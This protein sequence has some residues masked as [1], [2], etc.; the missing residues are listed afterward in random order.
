MEVELQAS[1]MQ[2]YKL[3]QTNFKLLQTLENAQK[4]AQEVQKEVMDDSEERENLIDELVCENQMLRQALTELPQFDISQLVKT[5]Q[6]GQSSG[7]TSTV[8]VMQIIRDGQGMLKRR[9]V[10]IL[11]KKA[12]EAEKQVKEQKELNL[13]SIQPKMAYLLD[14]PKAGSLRS[15]PRI[16]G[17]SEASA[18]N[19]KDAF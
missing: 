14:S 16:N 12:E 18:F 19:F 11:Q 4:N 2:E 8:D 3:K 17:E 13:K 15:S 7:E 9:Q 1:K 10:G 6:D 5:S